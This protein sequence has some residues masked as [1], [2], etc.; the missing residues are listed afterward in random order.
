MK[1]V[2]G[3]L[4]LMYMPIRGTKWYW[5]IKK[6][7]SYENEGRVLLQHKVC[8]S[9]AC[10]MIVI[11]EHC[12]CFNEI[13]MWKIWKQIILHKSKP[14]T[15]LLLLFIFLIHMKKYMNCSICLFTLHIHTNVQTLCWNKTSHSFSGAHSSCNSRSINTT[16]RHEHQNQYV[17]NGFH[18]SQYL[19]R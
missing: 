1:T 4:I 3:I 18:L 10:E 13:W 14:V 16:N 9:V 5:S 2:C 8:I 19:V 17:E 12:C 11:V 6:C 15:I 7:M